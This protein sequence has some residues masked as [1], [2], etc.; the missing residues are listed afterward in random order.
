MVFENFH[1]I[2][3]FLDESCVG[4][5]ASMVDLICCESFCVMSTT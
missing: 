3:K 2:F 5:R 4:A 1:D